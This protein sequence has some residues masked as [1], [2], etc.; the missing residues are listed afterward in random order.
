MFSEKASWLTLTLLKIQWHFILYLH[1]GTGN[2]L[3][4]DT[5]ACQR[6]K[7]AK[8]DDWLVWLIVPRKQY[9]EAFV[10]ATSWRHGYCIWS[11]KTKCVMRLSTGGLILKGGWSLCLVKYRR[12]THSSRGLPFP[13]PRAATSPLPWRFSQTADRN[14]RISEASVERFC[15]GTSEYVL[16][17][18]DQLPE[19]HGQTMAH[20]WL[21]GPTGA[22][23]EITSRTPPAG[24]EKN[25]QSSYDRVMGSCPDS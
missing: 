18:L 17:L 7:H 22:S 5:D 6:W 21:Q 19:M 2:A 24:N 12:M 1:K 20:T 14:Y 25:T 16:A 8:E 13:Q 9:M 15:D 10:M 23:A 3:V 4:V 11:K